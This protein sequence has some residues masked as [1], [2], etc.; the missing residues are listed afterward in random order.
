MIIIAILLVLSGLITLLAVYYNLNVKMKDVDHDLETLNE[1]VAKR[2]A[3]PDGAEADLI[4]KVDKTVAK[5]KV[6]YNSSVE[7]FNRSVSTFPGNI[8][9]RQERFERRKPIVIT[10]EE[11]KSGRSGVRSFEA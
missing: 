8:F 11:E 7:D 4:A 10:P 1:A 2:E 5:A 3:L 6:D 9:G